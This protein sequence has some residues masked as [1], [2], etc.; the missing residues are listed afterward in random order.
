MGDLVARLALQLDQLLD[1]VSVNY[2]PPIWLLLLSS[3]EQFE[4]KPSA[5]LVAPKKPKNQVPGPRHLFCFSCHD[6][7]HAQPTGLQILLPVAEWQLLMV[8]SVQQDH[9][10]STLEVAAADRA[11]FKKESTIIRE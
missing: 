8:V 10:R 11:P 9:R 2:F 7:D 6:L 1:S 3:P 4:Q 5:D